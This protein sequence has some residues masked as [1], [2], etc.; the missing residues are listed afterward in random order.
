[1][2]DYLSIV[3]RKL[4][5]AEALCQLAEECAELGQAALK[6]RRTITSENPTPVRRYDADKAFVEEI[7]D[8]ETCLEVLQYGQHR[9]DIDTI[10]AKKIKRWAQR[11]EERDREA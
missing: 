6:L 11:L 3:Q 2:E 4:T 1:M 9:E 5:R 8:L 7:A 10:K